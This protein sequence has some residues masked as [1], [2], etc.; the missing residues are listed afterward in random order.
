MTC[1]DSRLRTYVKK[2]HRKFLRYVM[3]PHEYAVFFFLRSGNVQG[4]QSVYF[5]NPA[6]LDASH[7]CCRV[8][9]C[10][11]GYGS[12][13]FSFQRIVHRKE[14]HVYVLGF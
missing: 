7:A 9:F 5:F 6:V 1:G 13:E 10:D 8:P 14:I 2:L 11:C 12:L 3:C 4:N